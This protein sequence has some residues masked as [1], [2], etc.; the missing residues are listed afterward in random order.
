MESTQMQSKSLSRQT[1]DFNLADRF[2]SY[3]DVSDRSVRT[4]QNA[5]KQF[6]R[7]LQIHGITQP[8]RETILSYRTDLEQDH[9]PNT[10]N[11]YLTAIR[12]FFTWTADEG[13][14]PNVADRIKGQK[15]Q[16]G[17]RKDALTPTQA[18][19][20][21]SGMDRTTIQGKRDYAIFLLMLSCGLRDI[22]VSRAN[23]DDIRPLGNETVLYIQ[24]KGRTGKDEFVKL[25]PDTET[26][27]RD[28]L[29]FSGIGSGPLFISLCHRTPGE[30]LTTKSISRIVKNTLVR[31]GFNSDR[32]TAHSLRHSAVTMALL[33]GAT[34]QQAAQFARHS[35]IETTMIYAH[36][37][38]RINNPCEQIISD[39]LAGR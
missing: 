14:Y 12:L 20:I 16:R 28:Y 32:L 27:I 9:S 2:I 3:L 35:K 13:I 1:I 34:I 36:N 22:E 23:V 33:G 29:A 38:E 4:Y 26:A 31:A 25:E 39:A 17:F 15:I 37:L 19:G 21:L 10:V 30:R 7:Y 8:T 6:I 11:L 24:G 18:K 5:L